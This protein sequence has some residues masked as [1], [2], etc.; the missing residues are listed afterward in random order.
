MIDREELA[1]T[2]FENK[3]AI[4]HP[5]NSVCNENFISVLINKNSIKWKNQKVNIVIL[6]N[7]NELIDNE[8]VENFYKILSEYLTNNDKILKSMQA[9]NL[10]EFL[11]E[12]LN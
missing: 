5:L 3:V 4:P 8:I 1:S 9:E 10:E 7:I 11:K 6:I 2:C 12:F